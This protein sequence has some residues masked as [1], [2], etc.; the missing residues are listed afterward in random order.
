MT[1]ILS[2]SSARADV[3]I[4]APVWDAVA[5]VPRAE[6]HLLLTGAHV[7]DESVARA[8]IPE[9]AAV[10]RRGADLAG[11]DGAAV[12]AAM[13]EIA[14]ATADL[15]AA[16]RP[17]VVLVVG[18]RL[19][20]IPAALATLP[21]NVPLAHLHGGEQTLGAVDDRVRHAMTKLAHLHCVANV[22][23]A[24][25]VAAMGEEPW[26]I[27]VTGAPGLDLLLGEDIVTPAEFAAAAGVDDLRG[28]R[29]VT[30]HPETNSAEP[31]APLEAVLAALDELPAPT[32]FTATNADPGAAAMAARIDGYVSAR[33]WARFRRTLGGRLYANALRHAALMLGNSSS[34][35]VEAGTFGLPV[36]NVGRRQEGRMRGA[37]V[38][39]CP[40]DAAAVAALMR[41]LA[42]RRYPPD[43]SLYGDGKAGPRVAQ[44]LTDLP[45]RRRLL[46]KRFAIGTTSFTAPW[47]APIETAA[48]RRG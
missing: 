33:P 35:I 24:N 31:A 32:L 11:R 19:D 7:A 36:I 6:L 45:E 17:D 28:L 30:V 4:L 21:F 37:N 1:K 48:G 18:D 26:R 12:G 13:A 8:A 34:G 39:D 23:A 3:G 14:T 42:G 5:R 44:V 25:R 16:I 47:C 38:H 41:A 40:S 43:I 20:M 9:Q 22:D 27:H 15:L 29:L 2:V 10:H 46:D